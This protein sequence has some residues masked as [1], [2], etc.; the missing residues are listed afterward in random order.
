MISD[1]FFQN[2][3]PVPLS[4]HLMI[5]FLCDSPPIPEDALA[6]LLGIVVLSMHV[7]CSVIY[8]CFSMAP[9]IFTYPS[10]LSLT[11]YLTLILVKEMVK[12]DLLG[13]LSLLLGLSEFR[14]MKQCSLIFWF[15]SP[16]V[17]LLTRAE[18]AVKFLFMT[19][20]PFIFYLTLGF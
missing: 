8:A 15:R 2:T 14:C 4:K 16:R 3:F 5:R 20:Q 19:L 7:F 17:V 13:F 10:T 12:E 9:C 6:C 18:E 11:E 1:L